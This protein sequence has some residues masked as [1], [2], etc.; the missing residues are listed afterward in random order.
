MFPPPAWLAR[1]STTPL[2]KVRV[3]RRQ[4]YEYLGGPCH[5]Y[6]LIL[7]VYAFN[8]RGGSIAC[9]PLSVLALTVLRGLLT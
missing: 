2:G 5:E 3:E 8:D 4:F 6:M 7:H 9:P 1:A